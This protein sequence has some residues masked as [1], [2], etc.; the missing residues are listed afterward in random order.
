M[1]SDEVPCQLIVRTVAKKPGF[2]D[3]HF[4]VL[5]Q[6]LELIAVIAD[7]GFK[8]SQR[9]ASYCLAEISDK[10]SDP[11]TAQQ[12]K[13]ALSKIGEQCTLPYVCT[14]IVGPIMEGKN[15]KNQE[16]LFVWLSQAIKEFGF[17][18]IDLKSLIPH[19]KSA[20]SNSNA[21]V[22]QASVQL[23]SVIYM[24]AG[25]NFQGLFDSEKPA[26]KDLIAA[27]IEKVK[28]LK[29]P[30]PTRGKNVPNAN[31]G[32]SGDNGDEAGGGDE[33]TDDPVQL[34]LQQE[35]LFPRV[36]ISGSLDD[37]LMDQMNDKNWKERQAALEKIENILRD[38]KFIE[39]NLNEL[40]TNLN[41]RLTDTNKILATTSL[42][43]SE[44]LAQALG[45]QGELFV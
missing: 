21:S 3:A 7:Q 2:K 33:A 30:V 29:P 37:A 32:G 14:Q 45:S 35:A 38:N 18:G 17:Q 19:L 31:G 42:K 27:E 22:R 28:D 41:K 25:A 36:D 1:P 40:P 16:H 23:I 13:D 11:K 6:R 8:F 20:L 24:Y 4:Q 12:A 39:P 9:S 10:I 26:L 43:I 5:K 44:K 34:Q 15:P